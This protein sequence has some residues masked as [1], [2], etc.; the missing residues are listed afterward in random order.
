MQIKKVLL[1]FTLS[2]FLI[3]PIATHAATGIQ[4]LKN[5]TKSFGS[6][7]GLGS[8]VTDENLTEKVANII[9]IVLS[10]LGII[11]VVIIIYAGFRWMMAGGNDDTVREAKNTLKNAFIGLLIIFLS[12]GITSFV[13]SRIST[14]TGAGG[15][16]GSGVQGRSQE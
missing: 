8:G 1:I 15:G 3:L 6:A 9:N 2:S 11:A 14:A 12:Y 10:V 7:T 5:N 4:N 13:I 16:S